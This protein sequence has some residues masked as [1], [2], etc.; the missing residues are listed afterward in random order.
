M[1]VINCF[2]ACM[3]VGWVYI[4]IAEAGGGLC[5]AAQCRPT[6]K[7]A[8]IPPPALHSQAPVPQQWLLNTHPSMLGTHLPARETTRRETQEQRVTALPDIV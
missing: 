8:A 4:I 3:H 6:S 2:T 7:W 1:Y 5:S